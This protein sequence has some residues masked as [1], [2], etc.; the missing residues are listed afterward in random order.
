[1]EF[2]RPLTFLRD[3]IMLTSRSLKFMALFTGCLVIGMV[4][5]NQIIIAMSLIPLSLLL[6]GFIVLT[7]GH[8]AVKT[9]DIKSQVQVGNI[10]ELKY[11]VTV[12]SGLG[13]I[14]FVPGTA[15][16]FCSG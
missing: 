2:R 7:P 13:S 5:G 8:L 12:T 9:Q 14:S 6:L 4:L 3:R 11:E 1:M 10:I 16:P 15:T